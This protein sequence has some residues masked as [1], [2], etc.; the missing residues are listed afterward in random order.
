MQAFAPA[1]PSRVSRARYR[2]LEIGA[3]VQLYGLLTLQVLAAQHETAPAALALGSSAGLLALGAATRR[4]AVLLVS[5][6]ALI[7]NLWVQYFVRLVGVF[8]LSVRL[9]G[10]GVGLLVGGV[11]YEQQVKQRLSRLKDWG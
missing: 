7:V 3:L 1:L 8:P 5:A 11:L 9:V 2:L 10:F 6:A 4:A